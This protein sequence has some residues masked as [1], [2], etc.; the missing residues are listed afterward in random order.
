[1]DAIP[2]RLRLGP[3]CPSAFAKATAVAIS[4]AA[5]GSEPVEQPVPL[6]AESP[7]EYPP[8]LYGEDA[9]G[10]V[11][12]R[13]L[14]NEGGRVDSV[15]VAQGSGHTGLDSAAVESARSMEFE[16]ALK[17]GEPVAAWVDLPVRFA[18]EAPAPT[19]EASEPQPPE[20]RRP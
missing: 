11:V 3:R 9:E 18:K 5:C 2:P 12:L 15:A 13:L 7:V 4:L 1:M 14:V 10:T 8:A 6:V 20:A 16:P 19:P 17:G